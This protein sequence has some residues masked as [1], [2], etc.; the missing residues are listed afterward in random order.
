MQVPKEYS[1]C[2]TKKFIKQS[3]VNSQQTTVNYQQS[4]DNRQQSTDNSQQST[5]NRQQST[6]NRQQSTINSQQTTVNSQQSTINSQQTT[7]NRQQS[8]D[9]SQQSTINSQQTTVNN[10]QSTD[11]SQQS[12]VNKPQSTV[13]DQRSTIDNYAFRMC[14]LCCYARPFAFRHSKRN[15]SF[16]QNP[17]DFFLCCR[18]I[19]PLRT[20]SLDVRDGCRVCILSNIRRKDH[21]D[22]DGT[23]GMSAL[24]FDG[25]RFVSRSRRKIPSSSVTTNTRVDI[26]QIFC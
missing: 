15:K 16:V 12:T 22:I 9:N 26:F 17:T 10:Q 7:V 14:L 4:T 11:N 21:K 20:R 5:V 18:S 2:S 8:T 19:S 6:I 25:K 24:R 3:T 13:N 1:R 23:L